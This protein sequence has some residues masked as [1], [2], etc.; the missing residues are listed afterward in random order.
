MV[1]K[2]YSENKVG[3]RRGCKKVVGEFVKKEKKL[4]F[5]R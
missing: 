4:V 1:I 3:Y 2:Y 5:V